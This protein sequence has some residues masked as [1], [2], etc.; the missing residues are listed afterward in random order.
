[1]LGSHI[2]GKN[3]SGEEIEIHDLRT[4]QESTFAGLHIEFTA[5]SDNRMAAMIT[6]CVNTLFA[7]A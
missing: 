4:A 1:M 7:N 2:T 3:E 5:D 6:L